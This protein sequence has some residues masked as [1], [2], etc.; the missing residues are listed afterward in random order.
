M[1]ILPTEFDSQFIRLVCAEDTETWWFSAVD[2]VQ[3]LTQQAYAL[4]VRK[5]WNQLKRRLTNEGSQ[6]AATCHQLQ[7]AAADGKK[8][9]TGSSMAAVN[10][11]LPST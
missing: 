4:A 8:R 10:S 9:L 11:G 7:M 5:Y 2:V 1:K 6:W 3:L